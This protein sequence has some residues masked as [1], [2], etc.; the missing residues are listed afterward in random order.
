MEY[1]EAEKGR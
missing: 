1:F